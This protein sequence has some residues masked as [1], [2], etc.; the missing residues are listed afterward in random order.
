MAGAGVLH[1]GSVTRNKWELEMFQEDFHPPVADSLV[2]EETQGILTKYRDQR[3]A[4]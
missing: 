3:G 1:G 2:R 4:K